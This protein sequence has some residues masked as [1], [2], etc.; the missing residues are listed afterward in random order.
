MTEPQLTLTLRLTPSAL[1][2]RRGVVRLHREVIDALGL[3]AWDAV[4]LI[5]SRVS[6]ALAAPAESSQPPGVVLV[7]DVTLSNVGLT[8][9]SEVVV[10]PA[11]V[12]HARTVTVA[13]SRMATLSLQAD[14]LRLALMG[15][16]F[17]AG[18]A[19]SLLP[20]DLAPEPG[21]GRL[22]EDQLGEPSG[23]EGLR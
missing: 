16:V 7:D 1:D 15:K 19:I 22:A 20:Q 10:A 11:T 17:T 2:A 12:A 6:A 18:D 5:G 4:R 23:P 9:G 21:V 3:R 8:E 14:T 13:G